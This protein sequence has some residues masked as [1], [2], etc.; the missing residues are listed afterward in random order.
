MLEIDKTFVKCKG[1]RDEITLEDD[2]ILW[3]G[4]KI[5]NFW[6]TKCLI[7]KETSR[8]RNPLLEKDIDSF[9][10]D[11][12]YET[13]YQRNF[14]INKRKLIDWLH[15][16]YRAIVIPSH[17][18]ERLDNVFLGFYDGVTQ[19]IPPEHIL[20]MWKRKANE[21]VKIKARNIARGFKLE[22]V[23]QIQYDLAII[24]S[25][26]DSYL[27]WKRKIQAH[28]SIARKPYQMRTT[29]LVSPDLERTKKEREENQRINDMITQ[30]FEEED[31]KNGRD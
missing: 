28:T 27:E 13:E 6:H 24:L 11:L 5:K 19:P 21:L 30:M 12:K 22:G 8:K 3:Y 17:F 7:K 31:R 15:Q 10:Q 1:C 14:Y 26:Y 20:D 4:F 2:D 16:Y 25:K 23:N 29:G 9:I 18:I